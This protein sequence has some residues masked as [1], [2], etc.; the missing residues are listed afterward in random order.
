M[1]LREIISICDLILGCGVPR[2]MMRR[3]VDGVSYS[4]IIDHGERVRKPKK[5]SVG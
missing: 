2:S 5:L 4:S 1:A 3:V